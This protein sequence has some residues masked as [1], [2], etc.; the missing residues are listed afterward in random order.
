M[1]HP[2]PHMRIVITTLVIIIREMCLVELQESTKDKIQLL[3]DDKEQLVEEL[4]AKL[5][6]RRV[7]WIFTDLLP[8]DLQKGT[9][10]TITS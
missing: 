2:P 5:G 8:E 10:R 6:L 4:A 7:G 3:P 9:V 1:S